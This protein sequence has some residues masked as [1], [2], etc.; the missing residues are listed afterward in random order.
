MGVVIISLH[1]NENRGNPM[2]FPTTFKPWLNSEMRIYQS[3][4]QSSELAGS[5]G[6]VACLLTHSVN[7]ILSFSLPPCLPWTCLSWPL[8][9]LWLEQRWGDGETRWKGG[10][11]KFLFHR[12][13]LKMAL[14]SMSLAGIQ[15]CSFLSCALLWTLRGSPARLPVASPLIWS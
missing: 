10:V 15:R 5:C 13:S 7:L 8:A 3:M 6:W 9:L 1:M 2:A 4:F 11:G 12:Y 14:R